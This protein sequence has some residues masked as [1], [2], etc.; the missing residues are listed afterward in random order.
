M[1]SKAIEKRTGCAEGIEDWTE[2]VEKGYTL[3]KRRVYDT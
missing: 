1:D 3:G 2:E